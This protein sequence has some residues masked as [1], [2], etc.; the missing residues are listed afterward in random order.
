M[1]GSIGTVTF[2]ASEDYLRTFRDLSV[3]RKASYAEHKIIGRH[4]LLEFT[5]L[6]AATCSLKVTFDAQF[7][8]NPYEE[9]TQLRDLMTN[10]EPVP[11]VL[12]GEVIGLGLWVV[13]SIN[14]NIEIVDNDGFIFRASADIS[15]K[16]W[17]DDDTV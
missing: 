11:F 15:L 10:H 17:V 16:E 2:V 7:G 12:A 14:A 9:M 1:I 8:L 4:S 6:D 13:E 3:S 5:G